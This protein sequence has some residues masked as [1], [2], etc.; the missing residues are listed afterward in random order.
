[1]EHRMP[2]L[3]RLTA[4]IFA[5][6]LLAGCVAP[7]P[8]KQDVATEATYLKYSGPPIDSFTYLGRYD[9]LQIL[10][11]TQVVIWTTVNDA[12]LLE[13]QAPCYNLR[14]ANEVSLTSTA[15]T[16]SS[17]FDYVLVGDE[18]CR[19]DSI[20]HID[21]GAVQRARDATPS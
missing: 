1:M 9:G 12:Y 7:E 3:T 11:S 18:R 13:V 19:I 5:A 10:G 4:F 2:T 6:V 15:R 14:L 16:V 20:R 17:N 21:Y 8:R